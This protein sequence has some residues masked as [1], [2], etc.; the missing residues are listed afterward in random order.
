MLRLRNSLYFSTR[1]SFE[2]F[3]SRVVFRQVDL[4]AN[5]ALKLRMSH[6][7]ETSPEFAFS[8]IQPQVADSSFWTDVF[9]RDVS[10]MNPFN[11]KASHEF[12]S[13][14]VLKIFNWRNK[15][16]RGSS[17]GAS[18]SSAAVLI[19]FAPC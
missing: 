7:Q 1:C 10:N 11:T 4:A 15:S 8:S 17:L 19:Q 2:P 12:V 6:S 18:S 5:S 3:V 13:S 16:S 9:A 14:V